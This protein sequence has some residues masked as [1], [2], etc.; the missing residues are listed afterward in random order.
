MS[1]DQIDEK[2]LKNLMVDARVS[3]R[4][5]A[6]KIGMST[7]TILSRI[8]KLEKNNFI[9]GYAARLDHPKLGYDITAMIEVK[10]E[11]GKMIEVENKIA[12]FEN[13]CA[14]YDVTGTTD[15]IIIAKFK[16][17]DALSKFVKGLATIHNIV[18]TNTHIVLNEIKEDFRIL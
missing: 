13:V 18:S 7:V 3:A 15:T 11:K 16:N 14:V 12:K 9:T 10:A 2:I 1:I 17:R 4:Q 6:L 8:K 5:L